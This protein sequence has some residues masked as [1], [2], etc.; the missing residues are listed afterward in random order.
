MLQSH[1]ESVPRLHCPPTSLGLPPPPPRAAPRFLHKVS[2]WAAAAGPE[3]GRR[4]G[5]SSSGGAAGWQESGS[6]GGLTSWAGLCPQALPLPLLQEVG[7]EPQGPLPE[8]SPGLP[9]AEDL[10][11]PC[12]ARVQFTRKQF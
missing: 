3:L 1:T 7:S 5:V 12:P 11:N 6:R 2:S 4:Q 8:P 9:S 10:D